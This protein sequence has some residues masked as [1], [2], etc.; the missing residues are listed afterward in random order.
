M[1]RAALLLAAGLLVSSAAADAQAPA[2]HPTS[3]A[4]SRGDLPVPAAQ[5]PRDSLRRAEEYL[6]MGRMPDAVEILEAVHGAHAQDEIAARALVRAYL[7]AGRADEAVELCRARAQERGGEDPDLW[8]ELSRCSLQAGRG[9]EAADALLTCLRL[10]PSWVMRLTDPFELAVSDSAAGPAA[11]ARLESAA[12]AAE[13]NPGVKEILAQ[14]YATAGRSAEAIALLV[15]A[16]RAQERKGELLFP[17]AHTLSRRGTPAAALAAYDSV[18]A[19]GPSDGTA[20]NVWFEKG[21]L[22]ASLGRAP[23]AVAAYEEAVRRFPGGPLFLRATIARA[24]LLMT[25]VRDLD[26]AR[27][28]Y[29]EVLAQADRARRK[30]RQ[31][32]LVD[33]A[34]LALAEC[35]LRQGDLE[36]ATERFGDLEK[37]AGQSALREAAAFQLAEIHFFQGRF[38][39]AEE[40]YYQLTDRFPQGDW[41]NDAFRRV[42]LLGETRGGP[43]V[44]Q[45]AQVEYLRR[46]DRGDEALA[47]CRQILAAAPGHPLEAE[48]RFTEMRLLGDAGQW[49]AADSAL[50]RILADHPRSRAA[51]AAL[52]WLGEQSSSEEERIERGTE[53]LERVL[54]D[55]PGSFEARRARGLL[56][57][58][59]E[60]KANS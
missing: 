57:G 20:E 10:R 44:E 49:A 14:V 40:A 53:C 32:P 29:E 33:R 24:D 31:Q 18:L 2:E 19:L 36:T 9:E 45:Y 15:E 12:R 8:I 28:A 37:E 55:Y 38:V 48:L 54:L 22:L 30:E 11:L 21:E 51:P 25:E 43:E 41:V 47:A 34:R 46:L 35:A 16:D 56:R 3:P 4:R 52:L 17:L 13:T 6:R 59:R 7:L 26:G 39:E 60:A 58:L 27:Q 23:E 5:S 50:T 1:S 42:L